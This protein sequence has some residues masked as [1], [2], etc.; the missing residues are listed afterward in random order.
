MGAFSRLFNDLVEFGATVKIP[1]PIKLG[2]M[3][4]GN[5]FP[6]LKQVMLLE[7]AT[8][9]IQFTFP[10]G[11]DAE[12]DG[13]LMVQ[14]DMGVGLHGI[15]DVASPL[16][17]GS[18]LMA[19]DRDTTSLQGNISSPPIELSVMFGRHGGALSLS[20]DLNRISGIGYQF[21]TGADVSAS[22]P[23]TIFAAS[24]KQGVLNT[25]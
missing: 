24:V 11:T 12:V 4:I 15:D 1:G 20:P 6:E 2:M 18:L 8:V 9:A 19:Y 16:G 14:L 25:F 7:G 10:G 21:G 23:I 5:T 22:R 13:A 3:S 17:S